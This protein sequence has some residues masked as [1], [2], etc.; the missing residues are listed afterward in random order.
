ME[1]FEQSTQ[2]FEKFVKKTIMTS[3][4]ITAIIFLLIGCVTGLNAQ[5]TVP[6]IKAKS[7]YASARIGNDFYKDAWQMKPN[8]RETA[9]DIPLEVGDNGILMAIITDLDSIGYIIKRGQKQLFCIILNEKDTVWG[10]FKGNLPKASFSEVYKKE[11]DGKTIIEVPEPYELVNVIMAIT[12]TGIRDSDLI[13]HTAEHYP[14]LLKQFMPFKNHRAVAVMDSLLKADM[15]FDIK[16]DAYSLVF[17]GDKLERKKEYDRINWNKENMILPYVPLFEDF[18]KKSKFS[19]FYKK[20]KPYYER[21]IR[22]YRDSLGVPQMQEW[23]NLNFPKTRKNCTKIIF[24][25][26][27]NANQS[28]T[29]FDNDN[30]VEAQA[31]VDFPN[32]WYNPQK[33][34]LSEKGFNIRRGNIVFTELNHGF[35]NPEFEQEKYLAELSDM[36]F[37]LDLFKDNK[38]MSGYNKPI[39]CVEEYMNW[40]L[41]S[42][43]F[44]DYGPKEDWENFFTYVE[45][46]QQN[47]RGFTQFK[48]FNRFLIKAYQERAKGQTVAD[49]YPQIIEWFREHNK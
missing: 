47:R 39:L 18:A 26:L 11:N 16:M 23:L 38:K 43:R 24:S 21:M 49:L 3:K 34:K 8:T 2:Y 44:M 9:D 35:E 37:N 7:P 42:L 46:D 22:A 41:V 29:G 25:P 5:N 12:P 40:A 10:I 30:F 33:T 20:N 31:H 14:M 1:L 27:V 36:K 4:N 45:N 28:A 13:E 19:S 48:A 32:F 17:K 6:T 15:Y